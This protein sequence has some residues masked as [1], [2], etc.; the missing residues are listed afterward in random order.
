[1]TNSN[2]DALF[3]AVYH[4]LV[5]PFVSARKEGG[6]VSHLPREAMKTLDTLQDFLV[7]G[8]ELAASSLLKDQGALVRNMINDAESLEKAGRNLHFHLCEPKEFF[9]P[10]GSTPVHIESSF[11]LALGLSSDP[12][13]DPEVSARRDAALK[14]LNPSMGEASHEQILVATLLPQTKK[15]MGVHT[16]VGAQ[17]F[18][19]RVSLRFLIASFDGSQIRLFAVGPAIREIPLP[20]AN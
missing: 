1:M 2:P 16:P 10:G 3:K 13:I 8:K 17:I 19:M 5:E 14:M 18:G 4:K 20:D 6:S 9:L 11:T 12:I 15:L 7:T